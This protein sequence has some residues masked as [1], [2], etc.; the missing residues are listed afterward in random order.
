MP[1]KTLSHR[2]NQSTFCLR[3]SLP[4]HTRRAALRHFLEVGNKFPTARPQPPQGNLN[5]TKNNLTNNKTTRSKETTRRRIEL[6]R[7]S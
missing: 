5:A 4:Q 3:R 1:E 7:G 2:L 6:R